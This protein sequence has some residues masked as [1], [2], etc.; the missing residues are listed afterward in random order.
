M[1]PRLR[2]V[3]VCGVDA[4]RSDALHA[5]NQGLGSAVGA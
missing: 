5:D 2:G 4:R 1:T 3:I